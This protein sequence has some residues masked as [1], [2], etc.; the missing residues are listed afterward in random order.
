M[1]MDSETGRLADVSLHNDPLWPRAGDWPVQDGTLADLILVD[2][3]SSELSLSPSQ[4]HLT[5]AAVRDALR[6]YSF[7]TPLKIMDSGQRLHVLTRLLVALGGDNSVT[8]PVAR[9]RWGSRI[10]SAG[11]VTLDAHHDLRD[12]HSNGSPVRELIEAGLDGSRVVQV[13]IEPFANSAAYRQRARDFGITVI[14]RDE[15]ARRGIDDS[16]AEALEIAGGAGGPVHVDLDVD[17]C[18]RSVAPACPASVPGGL[19]AME[20]R[21]A[22]RL[23]GAHPLVESID[24]VEVDAA[25]DTPDGRTVRLVALCVLEAARGLEARP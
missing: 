25:A 5:P 19:S 12:G 18:D 4:A 15:V 3:P 16:M 2:A 17:V 10:L 6:R 11:L 8:V 23:A 24:L 1:R 21:T 14:T 9:A 13:G 20:L 22:A 7:E